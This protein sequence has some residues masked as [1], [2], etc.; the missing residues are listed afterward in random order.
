MGKQKEAI[1]KCNA[2]RPSVW[3]YGAPVWELG[4]LNAWVRGVQVCDVW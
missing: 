1:N 2:F 4:C 3:N